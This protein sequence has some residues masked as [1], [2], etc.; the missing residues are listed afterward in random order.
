[1]STA[2]AIATVTETLLHLLQQHIDTA[3]VPGATVTAM[4][5][6]STGGLPNPGVNIFLYQVSPNAALRNAD[7]PT[8][9]ANGTLL[10]RPQVALDLHYL[11]TF[12]GDETQLEQQRLLGSVALAMHANPELP[13]A[14]IDHVETTTSFLGGA[15]LSTQS[16]L[17]RFVPVNFTLEELSKLWSFLLKIDYVLSTAYRASVVLIKTDDPLPP[18]PAPV[19]RFG[20]Q[21]MPFREPVIQQILPAPGGGPL[22]LPQSQIVLTGQSLSASGSNTVV[23]FGRISQPASFTSNTRIVVT[24]PGSLAAGPQTVRVVQPLKL[25]MPPVPHQTGIQSDIATFV[26]HPQIQP[27]AAPGGFAIVTRR[28]F[29]S[30][31]EDVIEVKINPL[32]RAGQSAALQL[33]DVNQPATMHLFAAA[34]PTQDSDT[35]QFPV[36]GL[37][38][39]NYLARVLIDGATSPYSLD[40]SG[41]PVAPVITW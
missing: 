23:Q 3:H 28:N 41:T 15:G 9:S 4:P 40:P 13:R 17:V 12:Y 14:L 26:L 2:L 1:M 35:V 32:V 20:L 6:D 34:P 16:E 37:P 36:P 10:R 29:G 8:R 21:A 5:P 38:N 11:L 22:I 7:L 27:S 25:G 33:A 24:L 39:G 19:L 18:P 30:P 31:P